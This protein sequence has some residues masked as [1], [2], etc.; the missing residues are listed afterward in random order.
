M[1]NGVL[2]IWHTHFRCLMSMML[3]HFEAWKLRLM[4]KGLARCL[5]IQSRK[6]YHSSFE[7]VNS[8]SMSIEQREKR[9]GISNLTHFKTEGKKENS[10]KRVCRA[11]Y[12]SLMNVPSH[13]DRGCKL[14]ICVHDYFI[15]GNW[16]EQAKVAEACEKKGMSVL[17]PFLRHSTQYLGH[18][19][20]C[21]V[22]KLR[23]G[24]SVPHTYRS[25]SRRVDSVKGKSYPSNWLT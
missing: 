4:S 12:F 16:P 6:K 5:F 13:L 1:L 19:S 18:Y 8:S 2:R 17:L 9:D 14:T 24:N 20:S 21:S 15:A 10:R 3:L 25:C 23:G 7:C 11:Y 22:N